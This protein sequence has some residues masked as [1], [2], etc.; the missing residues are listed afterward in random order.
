MYVVEDLH[1]AALASKNEIY[2]FVLNKT[3]CEACGMVVGPVDDQFFPCVVIVDD[4][5]H[6]SRDAWPICLDCASPLLY[7]HEWVYNLNL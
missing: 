4:D 5:E 2:S 7:P 3:E 6:L 1:D